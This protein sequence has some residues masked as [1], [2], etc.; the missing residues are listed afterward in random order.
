MISIETKDILK[1]SN[2]PDVIKRAS[3]KMP[4]N[5]WNAMKVENRIIF[6]Y[7][8]SIV[9]FKKP[10][11]RNIRNEKTVRKKLNEGIPNNNG[12]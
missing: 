11:N 2:I 3:Q 1:K 4:K 8:I 12:L 9:R 10:F 6:L 5:I 7:L